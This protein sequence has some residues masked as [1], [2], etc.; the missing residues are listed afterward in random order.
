MIAVMVFCCTLMMHA[1]NNNISYQ[2]VVRDSTN[3]LVVNTPLTV[4]LVLTDIN[5]HTYSEN[6]S[7]TTNSNGMTSLWIGAGSSPSGN[8]DDLQWNTV[9]VKSTIYRQSD[10][11]HIITHTMPISAVPYAFYAENVN[12][13]HLNLIFG[14]ETVVFTANQATNTTVNLDS[15]IHK[16]E[17]RITELENAIGL[18]V[19]GTSKLKDLDNHFYETVEINS[20]CWMKTNLRTKKDK[21]GNDIPNG[22]TASSATM[23]YYYSS[24]ASDSISGYFYNWTAALEACPPGWHLPTESELNTLISYLNSIDGYKCNS[25]T[26]Y[27]AKALASES[28]WSASSTTCSVGN[29]L[30][31]N[32]STHFS[33]Y[34]AG[35]WE[36][37]VINTGQYATYWF[38]NGG[39][40]ACF[41]L[42]YNSGVVNQTT[43]PL[44]QYAYSIRCVQN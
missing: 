35:E 6:H 15:V 38:N 11:K 29:S 17:E 1:Q 28:G 20:Q 44:P 13:G 2:A 23:A 32:N 39:A 40:N 36:N 22:N 24:G 37:S 41:Y 18:F 25:Q 34:P 7:V 30:G 16:L 43:D 26:N 9:T 8:W 31:D 21:N 19:C 12:D 33:A 14:G 3:H 4:E 42:N 27:I 5:N 10:G